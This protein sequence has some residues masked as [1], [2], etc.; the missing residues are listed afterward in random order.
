MTQILLDSIKIIHEEAKEAT[1]AKIGG[2]DDL[3][4]ILVYVLVQSNLPRINQILAYME[5]FA[6]NI[7]NG[8][9]SFYMCCLQAGVN[10]TLNNNEDENNVDEEKSA[11]AN[12]PLTIY[13]TPKQEALVD[14]EL[15]QW[16]IGVDMIE[17]SYDML[18]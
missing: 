14:E 18:L 5:N 1:G 16:M 6:T 10:W 13:F 7:N 15:Q 11:Q 17:D 12:Q 2:M 4:P 9:A 3:L 8:E